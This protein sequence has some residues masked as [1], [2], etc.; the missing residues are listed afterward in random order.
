MSKVSVAKYFEG[1]SS[2]RWYVSASQSGAV[3]YRSAQ[4]KAFQFV[5]RLK[6]PKGR[7]HE[8]GFH[9]DRAGRSASSAPGSKTRHGLERKNSAHD[10]ASRWF[11][12]F[13]G[14]FLATALDRGRFDSVVIIAEPRFLGMIRKELPVRVKRSL[15]QE[16]H[17]ELFKVSD[18]KLEQFVRGE[19]RLGA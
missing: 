3:I 19:L 7:R 13:L 17:R 18:K 5:Q 8:S 15:E 1:G 2:I 4:G 12:R 6:F 11:A 9:S 10:E 16:V 14:T